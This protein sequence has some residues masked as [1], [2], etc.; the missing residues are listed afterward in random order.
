MVIDWVMQQEYGDLL[1]ET[2]Q[3]DLEPCLS[4]EELKNGID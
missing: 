1:K 4:Y 3:S 2:S